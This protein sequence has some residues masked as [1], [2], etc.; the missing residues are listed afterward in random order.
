MLRSLAI[1]AVILGYRAG[2]PTIGRGAGRWAVAL[3]SVAPHFA[4]QLVKRF[5]AA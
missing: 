2:R 4:G 1:R 5:P 3:L